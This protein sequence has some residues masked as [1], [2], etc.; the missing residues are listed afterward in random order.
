MPSA[1]SPEEICVLLEIEE[2]RLGVSRDWI[3]STGVI[4]LSSLTPAIISPAGLLYFYS[5]CNWMPTTSMTFQNKH[6]MV[7]RV[8]RLNSICLE[9]WGGGG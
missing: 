7:Y 5:W 9:L 2:I 4:V 6:G 8:G 3:I 1:I